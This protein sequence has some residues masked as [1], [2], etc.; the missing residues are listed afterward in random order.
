MRY[1]WLFVLKSSPD[2]DNISPVIWR[3]LN[4]GEHVFLLF[5]KKYDYKNDFRIKYLLTFSNLK[6]VEI[7]FSQIESEFWNKTFRFFYNFFIIKCLLVYFKV[8]IC[9]F[10]WGEG[11]EEENNVPL[12]KKIKLDFFSPI[13]KQL[14]RVSKSLGIP[15]VA[16]PHGTSTKLGLVK[17]KHVIEIMK[18]NNGKL[19][20]AD[21][22]SYT[23]YIFAAEYHMKDI[24]ANSNM[25]GKNTEVWGAVR[26]SQSWMKKLYEIT[27]QLDIEFSKLAYQKKVLFFTPKW[28]NNV[29]RIA[30]ISLLRA[31]S[32]LDGILLLIKTHPRKGHSELNLPELESL[33]R[34]NTIYIENDV[35][36]TSLIKMADILIE[37]DSS[38]AI[39]ALLLGKLFIHPK[40]LHNDVQMIYDQ[41]GGPIEAK[42]QQEVLSFLIN[43]EKFKQVLSK[44][45]IENVIGPENVNITDL[46]YTKLNGLKVNEN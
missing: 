20:F 41:W 22:D 40:Y 24:L 12:L 2:I 15:T 14:K 32:N 30:T 44:E 16:L 9:I 42:S 18:T 25:S 26:F 38:I 8:C 31:I 6:I 10:E 45:F 33:N 5:E 37:I 19:P 43:P 28:H 7:P 13:V 46:Y 35:P 11:I 17:S 27:P 39:D 3:C 4:A 21:R 1:P 29:D 36:S 34:S 23:K